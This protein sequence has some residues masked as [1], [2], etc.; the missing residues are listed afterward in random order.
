[1]KLLSSISS[2]FQWRKSEDLM[3]RVV[4]SLAFVT[5]FT[6]TACSVTVGNPFNDTGKNDNS[7][8]PQYDDEKFVS[9]EAFD[10][11]YLAC[12]NLLK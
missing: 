5:Y 1:M 2:Y 3:Y 9:E 11:A 7:T 10:G 4:T 8:Q 12:S 6:A